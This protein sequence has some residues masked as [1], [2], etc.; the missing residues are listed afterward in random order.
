VPIRRIS[1]PTP[2]DSGPVGAGAPTTLSAPADIAT[3]RGPTYEWET[4]MIDAL[5]RIDALEQGGGG[6]GSPGTGASYL[7]VQASPAATW[8][9]TH[10]LDTKPVVAVVSTGGVLLFAE[11]SYPNDNTTV[12]T[13][14]QPYAG[15]AYFR[16]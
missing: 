16:G 6:G 15:S 2:G 13:F 11:I 14:G 3:G 4:F 8:T 7:H 12:I 9:V 5:E 1:P 10:N